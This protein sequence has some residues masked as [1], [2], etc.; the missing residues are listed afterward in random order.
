MAIT[1][2]LAAKKVAGITQ[3]VNGVGPAD[4]ASYEANISQFEQLTQT[5]FTR[6]LTKSADFQQKFVN[7][8]G[9]METKL[10]NTVYLNTVGF[11]PSTKVLNALKAKFE[12]NA[13][14]LLQKL[15]SSP[16]I[17]AKIDALGTP[18][19][20]KAIAG[21][22]SAVP[23]GQD[24]QV[25]DY[26][27]APT[28]VTPSANV[29]S[30]GALV[31]S[32]VATLTAVDADTG[33][34]HTFELLNPLEVPFLVVDNKIVVKDSLED[35]D[36]DNETFVVRV[37]ATDSKGEKSPVIEINIAVTDN[38]TAPPPPN[39]VINL[40]AGAET[41][42]GGEGNDTFTGASSNIN[43]PSLTTADAG[44]ILNGAGGTDTFKLGIDGPNPNPVD[45]IETNSVEIVDITNNS[46][47][48]ALVVASKFNGVQQFKNTG[49]QGDL[50]IQDVQYQNGQTFA[51][52]DP[53]DS[54]QIFQ[55]DFDVTGP[56]AIPPGG[57]GSTTIILNEVGTN[58]GEGTNFDLLVT[59]GDAT[60]PATPALIDVTLDSQ[61]NPN[62]IDELETGAVTLTIIGDA[63]LTLGDEDEANDDLLDNNG[64]L[65][66]IV[67]SGLAANLKVE[68]DDDSGG[69][70]TGGRNIAYTGAQG[71]DRVEMGDLFRDGANGGL[72][73]NGGTG[74][75]VLAFEEFDD[76]GGGDGLNGVVSNFQ[77]AEFGDEVGE[78]GEETLHADQLDG[79][80]TFVFAAG[81]HD[82]G[83]IIVSGLDPDQTHTF[84]VE[85]DN[86]A[87][88]NTTMDFRVGDPPATADDGTA[89]TVVIDMNDD[90]LNMTLN[91]DEIE[92]FVYQRP[93]GGTNTVVLGEPMTDLT[94]FQLT[95]NET[96][97]DAGFEFTFNGFNNIVNNNFVY[98]GTATNADQN[99]SGVNKGTVKT[100]SGNDNV[101]GTDDANRIETGAGNDTANGG[102]GAD[103]ILGGAGSDTLTGGSGDDY[104][105]G[106][107][108]ADT[109][110]GGPAS[111]TVKTIQV[112]GIGANDVGD[113][114]V[115]R[116]QIDGNQ[117]GDFG[118]AGIDADVTVTANIANPALNSQTD[119]AA[120]LEAGLDG[121]LGGGFTVS[122]V[123]DTITV[124][125]A[126]GTGFNVA[127]NDTGAGSAAGDGAQDEIFIEDF[128]T[129]TIA[130]E[131]YD[132]GDT[133][134]VG[135]DTN[136]SLGTAEDFFTYVVQAGDTAATIAAALAGSINANANYIAAAVGNEIQIEGQNV[137][138]SF[139][140]VGAAA[141]NGT[142][143]LDL[144][145][146]RDSIIIDPDTF[147]GFNGQ[148][149]TLSVT[150]TPE[151][152]SQTFSTTTTIEDERGA[153]Q[154]F[155]NDH[156]TGILTFLGADD[157]DDVQVFERSPGD[158]AIR[159]V[160]RAAGTF[161][162]LAASEITVS[163]V[164]APADGNDVSETLLAT[165]LAIN[166]TDPTFT[167]GA[168]SSADD[169]QEGLL[170]TTTDPGE[171]SGRDT[172]VIDSPNINP[173]DFVADALD[174][175][176]D[177][178]AG[179]GKLAGDILVFD[180][181]T[182]DGFVDNDANNVLSAGDLD[183]FFD[184]TASSGTVTSYQG[185]FVAASTILAA[186]AVLDY[187]SVGVDTDGNL[188]TTNDQTT[189]VFADTAGNGT[190]GDVASLVG[191]V[192]VKSE[193]IQAD[194]QIA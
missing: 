80:R 36:F 82:N 186:N 119:I 134:R 160:S 150:F 173:F 14:G 78:P 142:T 24:L 180:G 156:R 8:F 67:A 172:F 130:D 21:P 68:L 118:D 46:P 133:V 102:R 72:P 104:L 171:A 190:I 138:F 9:L 51:W 7:S 188:A 40:A 2:L 23:F 96:V 50:E 65:A 69:D 43:Q 54:S 33:D 101:T 124:S 56:G 120:A 174:S 70:D 39:L 141:T 115:Y 122:V 37:Q 79:V 184:F 20:E 19:A 61:D 12:D 164:S 29:V 30:E 91:G 121:Q 187:V 139:S 170:V 3:A 113:G 185:A 176:T 73:F 42:N 114:D 106:G 168:P 109:L 57:T 157:A 49:S 35:A 165:N 189:F 41:S 146:I 161:D 128:A 55:I 132:I 17:A 34:T 62:F 25:V 47:D 100:G 163:L 1:N 149:E 112:L 97:A 90:D 99:V 10:I 22:L 52:T 147:R 125:E 178:E 183:R 77:T 28:N 169:F 110:T 60:G 148:A 92:T 175:I 44:D 98:D 94:L 154:Q 15:L 191:L 48:A 105:D 93:D 167:N 155:V 116:V 18:F 5:G 129:V 145:T 6:E 127:V 182:T 71:N 192:G 83:N 111:A 74:N 32:T 194:N 137:L 159:L 117:D 107:A 86:N 126:D 95:G 152:I 103:V 144:A 153:L 123:G 4:I 179:G 143:V 108:D 85:E 151:G 87:T 27:D 63:D 58:G 181:A 158:F 16:G 88:T 89:D 84:V 166:N 11:R 177:F 26:N 131:A 45:G 81:V 53:N 59:Q 13:A 31:G 76:I 162:D 135:M 75:N 136:G 193:D 140:V 66:A 38:D 64:N